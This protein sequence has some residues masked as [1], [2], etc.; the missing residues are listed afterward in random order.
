MQEEEG[1]TAWK[2]GI[3]K[4]ERE[5]ERVD[6]THGFSELSRFEFWYGWSGWIQITHIYAPPSLPRGN[7]T[8]AAR[9]H[10]Q[11]ESERER[12]LKKNARTSLYPLFY[13]MYILR[14]R[15]LVQRVCVWFSLLSAALSFFFLLACSIR[16]TRARG[17]ISSLSLI[18]RVI[19]SISPCRRRL[20]ARMHFSAWFI[21]FWNASARART[22]IYEL[23]SF[24]VGNME[25][26]FICPVFCFVFAF[27]GKI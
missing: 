3:T 27:G 12:L 25:E 1:K 9:Q 10:T 4:R 5:S 20:Y 22:Y 16:F 14:H 18:P 24:S 6:I 11:S 13:N 15:S 8:V 17:F 2:K 21:N 23:L 7:H 19:R 26:S